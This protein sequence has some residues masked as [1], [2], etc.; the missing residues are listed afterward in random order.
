MVGQ[1]SLHVSP[2][3][4]NLM[5]FVG[6]KYGTYCYVIFA[7]VF[8]TQVILYLNMAI[9]TSLYCALGMLH[10]HVLCCLQC[11]VMFLVKL[12][13]LVV[14]ASK[15]HFFH[16]TVFQTLNCQTSSVSCRQ[17]QQKYVRSE[18]LLDCLELCDVVYCGRCALLFVR[19]LL[20]PSSARMREQ[21]VT[22]EPLVHPKVVV[23]LIVPLSS[24]RLMQ[25][26]LPL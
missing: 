9:S 14:F 11:H 6:I 5:R 25:Y 8:I 13:I 7:L 19:N 21:A 26:S 4:P 18:V 15:M 24:A 20:P 23:S 2:L 17:E 22:F 1:A 3:S 16:Q 10:P 12:C